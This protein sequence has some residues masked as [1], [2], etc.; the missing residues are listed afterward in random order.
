ESEYF[1]S[2]LASEPVSRLA[3]EPVSRLTGTPANRLT[4]KPNTDEETFRLI[5]EQLMKEIIIPAITKDINE[6]QRYAPLRQVY[7]SLILAEW[8]KRK[9]N[10]LASEPTNRHTD[11]PAHRPTGTPANPYTPYINSGI[12]AGL[13]SSAPWSKDALFQEYLKSYTQG[14]YSIK[15]TI[16]GLKRMYFSGGIVMAF[17]DTANS[18]PIEIIP[19]AANSPVLV[20]DNSTLKYN[21]PIINQN[22]E[23]LLVN[24]EVI[25]PGGESVALPISLEGAEIKEMPDGIK[26]Y[27]LP[28]AI[29]K[30]KKLYT[31]ICSR[32]VDVGISAIGLTRETSGGIAVV[33]LVIPEKVF[34]MEN[35]LITACEEQLRKLINSKEL[36]L[37]LDDEKIVL[38]NNVGEKILLDDFKLG[39]LKKHFLKLTN[40]EESILSNYANLKSYIKQQGVIILEGGW[41]IIISSLYSIITSQYEMK[42]KEEA[43]KRGLKI[44]FFTHLHPMPNSRIVAQLLP[45]KPAKEMELYYDEFL[46]PSPADIKFMESFDI[47][48]FEIRAFGFPENPFNHDIMTSRWY[49]ILGFIKD[50]EAVKKENFNLSGTIGSPT[51]PEQSVSSVAAKKYTEKFIQEFGTLDDNFGGAKELNDPKTRAQAINNDIYFNSLW[52]DKMTLDEI[53]RVAAHEVQHTRT[54]FLLKKRDILGGLHNVTAFQELQ[55][56]IGRLYDKII[57]EKGNVLAKPRN[58]YQSSSELLSLLRG[59]QVYLK[60]KKKGIR[61]RIQPYE[62]I[63][64]FT[65][66]DL[67]F[68]NEDYLFKITKGFER[69]IG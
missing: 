68:L 1:V 9:V 43:K 28:E 2:R 11:K 39:F 51:V 57:Q 31:I 34:V 25:I 5:S 59:Y 18:S 69:E 52:L 63:E 55:Q 60:Q 29:N 50:I 66:K 61:T 53:E 46:R 67:H 32:K 62:F 45:N 8:Y 24:S 33:D 21:L 54:V 4:G 38:K 30:L 13:E 41:D 6:D 40:I 20:E 56:R 64:A 65:S 44:G 27:L 37:S 49:N 42:V 48:Y 23:S 10:R 22:G 58:H 19:V 35:Q 26:I 3:G 14:E 16:F 17:G 12:T 7:Y 15:D 47:R 36:Q